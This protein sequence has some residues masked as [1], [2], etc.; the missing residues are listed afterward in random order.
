MDAK[1][2]YDDNHYYL[3]TVHDRIGKMIIATTDHELGKILN[4]PFKLSK[5]NCDTIFGVSDVEDIRKAVNTGIYLTSTTSNT[6]I[7]IATEESLQPTKEIQVELEMKK[8]GYCEGC[9]KSGL[10]HCAHA[11][12]CGNAVELERP[13]LDEN[14]CVII[15]KK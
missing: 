15:K 14:G 2:T 3:E 6:L 13:K 9:T 10:W 5:Q 7:S 12:T 11:D 4:Y 8:Y 1:L